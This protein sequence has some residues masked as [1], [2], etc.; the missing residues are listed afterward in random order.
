MLIKEEWREPWRRFRRFRQGQSKRLQESL[1]KLREEFRTNLAI[2]N[3]AAPVIAQIRKHKRN[4]KPKR[5]LIGIFLTEHFGDIVACE[6][7][8]PWLRER[9]PEASLIWFT[10]PAYVDLVRYHPQ[11]DE[12][13]ELGSISEAVH[14][15]RTK[16]FDQV[17]DLHVDGK[18]CTV[19]NRIHKKTW[20]DPRING[21]NYYHQGPLLHAFSMSAGLPCFD[22]QPQLFLPDAIKEDLHRFELPSEYIV[23]HARSNEG[24]RNWRAQRWNELA[25]AILARSNWTLVEVGLDPVLENNGGRVVNLCS[26]LSLLETA[27][28][29]RGANG[30]I[31]IDSG[32]AHF[33]NAFRIPSVILLGHYKV[34]LRYMPYTGFLRANAAKM[35]I[36]WDGPASEIPVSEVMRRFENLSLTNSIAT[37]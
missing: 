8:I 37:L 16:L 3:G 21:D 34:Y 18:G 24:T 25:L 5:K 2:K 32:P 27:E 1:H 31:G 10:R 14:V 12:V 26:K 35:V 11:L 28:V 19:F 6:P 23:V 17:V 29:I 30:Y 20:G 7:V 33:A 9:N 4:L 13:M 15:L 22:G 36:Q